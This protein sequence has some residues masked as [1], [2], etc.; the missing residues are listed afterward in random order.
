MDQAYFHC[1]QQHPLTERQRTACE[2]FQSNYLLKVIISFSFYFN[3]FKEGCS[4]ARADLQGTLHLKTLI[5]IN[6]VHLK[7]K[8][9]K[10]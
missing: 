2:E 1:I 10:T 7:S 5:A 8:K 3:S 9:L 6:M 4:S